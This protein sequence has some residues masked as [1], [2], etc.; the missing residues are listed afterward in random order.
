M[1]ELTS[2]GQLFIEM[3]NE[4]QELIDIGYDE[5][6][7]IGTLRTLMELVNSND[8]SFSTAVR[9]SQMDKDMFME[10][11]NIFLNGDDF[12]LGTVPD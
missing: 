3:D 10:K 6:Y 12:L 2:F 11:Y 4:M 8:I 7:Y 1:E 5:G 9:K